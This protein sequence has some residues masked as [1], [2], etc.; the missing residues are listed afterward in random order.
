MTTEEKNAILGGAD[1]TNG[2][3]IN[4]NMT[5]AAATTTLTYI[6]SFIGELVDVKDG[7]YIMH[8]AEGLAKV[9]RLDGANQH[10]LAT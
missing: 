4:E 1:Q 7:I 6:S 5:E 3:T 8:N 10:H 2:N 9:V